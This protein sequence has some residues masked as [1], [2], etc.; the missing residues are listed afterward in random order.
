MN[1]LLKIDPAHPD[2]EL[3][4][5]A[6][7][8]LRQGGV[9]AAPTD[10]VYG[11][12]ADPANEAAVGRIYIVK[13]R[14]FCQPLILLITAWEMLPPL[15]LEIPLLARKAMEHFWPGG[16]TVI[17]PKSP[18]VPSYI[19][20]SE[21]IG[22]RWP[23]H[24]VMEGLL[25]AFGAPLASTSANR[26]GRPAATS[27]AAVQEALGG[28]IDLIIDAGPSP[29]GE[30]STVL[31]FTSGAIPRLLRSGSIS[32]EDLADVLGPLQEGQMTDE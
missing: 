29:L 16:L 8:A 17:L 14:D 30:P 6:A 13:G 15:C 3:L 18:A 12:F 32:P 7:A 21:T 5:Q 24:L 10:T 27:A 9:I 23:K 11:L 2:P 26:S 28:G 22:I 19:S 20:R 1:T 4:Q 31:D 25:K